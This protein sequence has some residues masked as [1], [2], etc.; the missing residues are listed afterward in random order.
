MKINVS[1]EIDSPKNVVWDTIIDINNCINMIS[2]I[3]DLKIIHQPE[4]GIVGLKWSEKRKMFGKECSEIMWITDCKD[5][6]YYCVR[7]ESGGAIY[8]TKM[9]LSEIGDKT[10]LTMSFSGTSSSFFSRLISSIMS[11][12]IKK[13]MVKMLEKDLA[14]IKE[15][16]ENRR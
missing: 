5:G 16:V 7:S 10:Q 15:Y 8:T 3:I 11:I 4:V 14:E 2:G 13:S 12:F 1:V 6:E 9:D